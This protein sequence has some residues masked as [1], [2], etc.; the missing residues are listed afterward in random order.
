MDYQSIFSIKGTVIHG[1]GI[2]KLI[3][4]PTANLEQGDYALNFSGVFISLIYWNETEYA[5]V[6]HIGKRPTIDNEEKVSIETHFLSFDGD[7][8][9][10]TLEIKLLKK[11]RDPQKF[12]SAS[13]LREQFYKDC[14]EARNFYRERGVLITEGLNDII[15]VN[16]MLINRKAR[17]VTIDGT[18]INLTPKEFELLQFLTIKRNIALSKE[19]LY[20]NVWNEP[21]NGCYHQVENIVSQLR[22]K[23]SK[24]NASI[25]EI[26]TVKGYGYKFVLNNSE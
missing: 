24:G 19:E 9:G 2:G 8:Y 12:P 13:L 18:P 1:R 6:T 25:G 22:K 4:M 10:Q 20:V 26:Q 15:I 17:K 5:G 11:L 21:P 14:N 23:L 3:G 7:L 16:G